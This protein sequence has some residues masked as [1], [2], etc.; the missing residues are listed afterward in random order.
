MR[1]T[2][3]L[4]ALMLLPVFFVS[5]PAFAQQVR[6]VDAAALTQ[7]LA[8]QTSTER[9]QRDQVQRLLGRDDVRQ[10]ASTMGLS[11]G[12]ASA[13]VATLS[14]ADLAAASA[15]AS[16]VET[17]LAGGSNTIII[18]TTTLLL[19]LIIAILVAG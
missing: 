15:R 4:V 5:S 12:Q 9:A 10:L 7:A 6:V 11:L 18:S 2:H 3:K 17:A 13:A 19:I 16:A 8:N 1:L 14:G